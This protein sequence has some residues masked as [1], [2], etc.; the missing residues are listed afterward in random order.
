[1]Q[2]SPVFDPGLFTP[3]PARQSWRRGSV[4]VVE[5]SMELSPQVRM[6]VDVA[7]PTVL[8]SVSVVEGASVQVLEA[9]TGAG[10][11][12]AWEQ[13][14]RSGDDTSLRALKLSGPWVRRMVV[15]AV[16]V[17]RRLPVDDAVLCLDEAV[18]EIGIDNSSAAARV[19]AW[20]VDGLDAVV[21]TAHA[22]GLPEPAAVRIEQ[23]LRS[24]ADVVTGAQTRTRLHA[25]VEQ[26]EERESIDEIEL[27]AALMRLIADHRQAS[28]MGLGG[29]GVR[30]SSYLVDPAAV[31][32]RILRWTDAE[33]GEI[34]V[35]FSG[36]LEVG[37]RIDARLATMAADPDRAEESLYAYAADATAGRILSV[38]RLEP[39]PTD[40]TDG[41]ED[42]RFEASLQFDFPAP[43][44]P[45]QPQ[46]VYGI[47]HVDTGPGRCRIDDTGVQLAEIDRLLI[48]CWTTHRVALATVESARLSNRPEEPGAVSSLLERARTAARLATEKL[49][50]LADSESDDEADELYTRA[51]AIDAYSA[52]LSA[53]PATAEQG[54][55]ICEMVAAAGKEPA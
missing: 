36:D 1:M 38:T 28:H 51:E 29:G 35:A 43:T 4:T 7:D 9:V 8:S 33:T 53:S 27:D 31:P 39:A 17:H 21:D 18:A 2:N 46:I 41:E 52:G 48:D 5:V 50:I 37:G 55:L 54:P 20:C 10:S 49:G 14:L 6:G 11:V 3:T 16:R 23:A 22:G 32:A 24:V 15:E 40:P 30:H 13:W 44:G 19:I 45:A 12:D 26:L 47:F 25:L 42:Q 34:K